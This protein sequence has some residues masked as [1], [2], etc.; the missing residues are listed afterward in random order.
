MPSVSSMPLD[1]CSTIS[2]TNRGYRYVS[3]KVKSV[4]RR[5][6]VWSVISTRLHTSSESYTSTRHHFSQSWFSLVSQTKLVCEYHLQNYMFD[7]TSFSE[8]SRKKFCMPNKNWKLNSSE[9]MVTSLVTYDRTKMIEI[10]WRYALH[11]TDDSNN[12]NL[13]Q[14]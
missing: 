3:L 12:N 11:L 5:P 2:G 10:I 1:G 7:A 4:A 14:L 9:R 13:F 6:W 8:N